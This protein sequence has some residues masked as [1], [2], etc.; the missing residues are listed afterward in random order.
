MLFISERQL[1]AKCS[2]LIG[3]KNM[4]LLGNA[5]FTAVLAD[6]LLI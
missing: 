2:Q 5:F 3:L 4:L 6:A 1:P